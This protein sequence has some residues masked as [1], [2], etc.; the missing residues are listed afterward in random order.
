MCSS[1]PRGLPGYHKCAIIMIERGCNEMPR[2]KQHVF[3]ARTTEEGLKILN[4]LKSK[5]N[6]SW[7][8]LVIDAVNA[9]YGVVVPKPPRRERPPKKAPKPKAGKKAKAGD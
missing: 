8:I 2:G 1:V 6:C 5:L 9:H 7:D 4:D 3:S